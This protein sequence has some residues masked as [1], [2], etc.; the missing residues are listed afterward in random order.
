MYTFS[1]L[2]RKECLKGSVD[3]LSNRQVIKVSLSPGGF[4]PATFD[5]EGEALGLLGGIAGLGQDGLAGLPPGNEFLQCRNQTD[6][7]VIGGRGCI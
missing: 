1:R 6:N 7:P 4:D 3:N 5:V 2:L